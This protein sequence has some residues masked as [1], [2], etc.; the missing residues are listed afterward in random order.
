M[1]TLGKDLF[2]VDR[3]RTHMMVRFGEQEYWIEDRHKGIP[4]GEI[5]TELLDADVGAYQNS[6]ARL[7]EALESG[8]G[9]SGKLKTVRARLMELPFFRY[10]PRR[11]RGTSSA[12]TRCGGCTAARIRNTSHG[13]E[14]AR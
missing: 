2:D 13:C 14:K 1:G 11:G 3:P 6:L 7:R 12:R 5:L 10:L 4:Y 9:Y 8:N